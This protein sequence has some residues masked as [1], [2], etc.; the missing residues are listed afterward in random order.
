MLRDPAGIEEVLEGPDD[1]LRSANRERGDQEHAALGD[2][3][4]DGLR[5]LIERFLFRLVR[6]AAV[7]RLDE[8]VVGGLD[9]CWVAQ[10]RGVGAAEVSGEDQG[11]G[12]GAPLHLNAQ[13][14]DRGAEDVAG[15]VEDG[16][17]AGSDGDRRLVGDGPEPRQRALGLRLVVQRLLDDEV[18]LG[19]IAGHGSRVVGVADGRVAHARAQGLLVVQRQLIDPRSDH[20]A[21]RRQVAGLPRRDGGRLV[22]LLGDL[23]LRRDVGQLLPLFEGGLVRVLR[24]PVALPLGV[25]LLELARV[26][27]H[28]SGQL[29]RAPGGVDRPF[30]ALGY[31]PRNE[32]AVVQVGVGQDDR[33]EGGGIVGRRDA[34]ADDLVGAALEHAAVD[35][36]TGSIGDEEEL[37]TGDGV[38]SAEEADFHTRILPSIRVR[39][40]RVAQIVPDRPGRRR[41]F[42][43]PGSVRASSVAEIGRA[44]GAG[45]PAPGRRT[46]GGR[47]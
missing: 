17:D 22:L 40:A 10:D 46:P 45:S 3:V 37:G 28:E 15:V 32:A 27:Q 31:D 4:L 12:R 16:G 19:R 21:V 44:G 24:R 41:R 11:P 36:H 20:M 23:L 42:R 26:E 6:A 30:E 7:G 9:D 43:P 29:D 1:L 25:F 33:V 13:L 34:V 18:R 5:E 38:G 8:Y 14:H 47:V 2:D 35:Q 39:R